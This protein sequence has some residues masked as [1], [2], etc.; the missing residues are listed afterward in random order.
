MKHLFQIIKIIPRKGF[1]FS[2]KKATIIK[3]NQFGRRS[4]WLHTIFGI[5]FIVKRNMFLM[6]LNVS[7]LYLIFYILFHH[8]SFKQKKIILQKLFL[9]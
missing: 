7:L 1:K 8:I 6:I 4:I 2:M 5:V 9:F 3:T